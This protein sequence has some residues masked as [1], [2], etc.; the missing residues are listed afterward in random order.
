[1]ENINIRQ[2]DVIAKCC[3]L[4]WSLE[5]FLNVVWT[6]CYCVFTA[7]AQSFSGMEQRQAWR[8]WRILQSGY[9]DSGFCIVVGLHLCI[10]T[11][12]EFEGVSDCDLA[13]LRFRATLAVVLGSC[14]Y[15]WIPFFTPLSS[16]HAIFYISLFLWSY[17]TLGFSVTISICISAIIQFTMGCRR[18]W[19]CVV[20]V[21][22]GFTWSLGVLKLYIQSYIEAE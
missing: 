4:N 15:A 17:C 10:S 6:K 14:S 5:S 18:L 13:W 11:W 12:F 8:H 7:V 1:M 22:W 21:P 3:K 16:R 19:F 20:L 9:F 2:Q